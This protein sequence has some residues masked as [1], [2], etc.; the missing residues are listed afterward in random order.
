MKK[1]LLAMALCLTVLAGFAQTQYTHPGI[2]LTQAD[3]DRIKTKVNNRQQPWLD[4][5]S[6]MLEER[7]A[8]SDYNAAPNNAN[9]QR[10]S[11]DGLAAYYN[12]LR[13]YV[14]GSTDNAENA[15]RIV[16][17]WTNHILTNTNNIVKIVD[18][19]VK[20][21]EL[22]M[23]PISQMMKTVELLRLYSGWAQADRDNFATVARDYFYPPCKEYRDRADTWPGWG[24]PAN[25]C[26][27]AIG[28][29][30]DDAEMVSEAID[31]F[32]N[33]KGG[34]C[35]HQGILPSGQC[36]EM[37]RDQPHA[38]IGIN[39]YSDFCRAA[40][41]QGID[42]YGYAD[43]LLAKGYEYLCHFNLDHADEVE[44]EPGTYCGHTFFYPANSNSVPSSLPQNRIYGGTQ[45]EKAYHH[46]TEVGGLAM[47]WTRLMINLRPS[48]TLRGTL[49]TVSDT[50]T[51]YKNQPKPSVPVNLTATP[52]AGRI[53]LDWDAAVP[54]RTN[55]YVIQ[56]SVNQSSGFKNL[57][58]FT[59]NCSSEYVDTSVGSDT[60]YYYRVRAIN[61]SGS[62]GWSAKV[63]ATPRAYAATL[64]EGW[65]VTDLGD[66][67]LA[68]KSAWSDAQ[69][70]TWTL[71]GSGVDNWNGRQAIGNFTH[72]TVKGDFDIRMRIADCV[73]DGNEIKVKVGIAV[74]ETLATNSKSVFMQLEGNGTRFARL[75]WRNQGATRLEGALGCDHTWSPVWFRLTRKGDT[76]TGYQSVD[77][78]KWFETGSCSLA[79][80][81]NVNAG[82]FVCSGA[83]HEDGFTATFDHLTI[84]GDAAPTAINAVSGNDKT[85]ADNAVYDLSGR[86]AG[87]KCLAAGIYVRNHRKFIVR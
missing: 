24:G 29:Y 14:G 10:M 52:G 45:Y 86:L 30:L 72:T 46:Y 6:K 84:T 31:N 47:P 68:G 7:S 62:S 32:K 26:C 55:G 21:A 53:Y 64:P 48:S 70:G 19:K 77:G 27:L 76:F 50:T 2:D 54:N 20:T 17:A 28:I 36:T 34:G 16:N 40:W 42:L 5:W 41:D 85:T 23:L 15:V 66:V 22:F 11:A 4:G 71:T 82:L 25:F 78:V 35:I 87:G 80:A 75:S 79:M 83:Y 33:G 69:G 18:G 61:Q 1:T 3:L 49:W 37:G 58:T 60:T 65:A 57:K 73:Q 9:R 43:N 56:R 8:R 63:S 74:F 44:W 59:G 67:V 81:D 13:W 39:A 12:I 38:E 51:V